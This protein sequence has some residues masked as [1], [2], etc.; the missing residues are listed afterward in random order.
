MV[1]G[2]EVSRPCCFVC[3]AFALCFQ[4]VAPLLCLVFE[5]QLACP[6]VSLLEHNS[7]ASG[8]KEMRLGM[9]AMSDRES[10]SDE[11]RKCRQQQI[12]ARVGSCLA[13]LPTF[14]IHKPHTQAH[15]HGPTA[16]Q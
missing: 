12:I 11:R 10:R 2:Q 9:R 13:G 8:E 3:F 6:C 5:R 4:V 1:N 16:L 15:R 7:K 14:I